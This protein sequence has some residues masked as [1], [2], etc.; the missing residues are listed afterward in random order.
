MALVRICLCLGL[1]ACASTPEPPYP[2]FVETALLPDSFIAGLPGVR[3]KRLAA[4]PDT[5]RSS[6]LLTLP[7]DWSFS[8]GGFP[9][10]S[11]EIYVVAGSV[12]LGEF[13]LDAGG[14]AFI[15]AGSTGLSLTS[16]A[17]AQLLYFLDDAVDASV[18]ETPLISNRAILSWET[19]ADAD[20]FGIAEKVLREDP[21][22]GART[23]LLRIEP[24]ALLPWRRSTVAEEGI[25]LEGEYVHAECVDGESVTGSYRRGGYYIRPP[26]AINGG[27]ESGARQPSVWFVRRRAA[28]EYETLAAC[29]A[30][31][32]SP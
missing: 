10:K 5:R 17:G 7:P 31:T 6:D 20:A 8:T 32:P 2:A 26:G 12:R 11:V 28:G 4:N 21:G 9:D 24:G 18:I 27:P 29:E 23:W 15:P 3:S 14:Y 16:A 25:L 13:Q 22:S 30:Q 19:S 1:A